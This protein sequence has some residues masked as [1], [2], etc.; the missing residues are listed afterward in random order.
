MANH[1]NFVHTR[2]SSITRISPTL[3]FRRFYVTRTAASNH[4]ILEKQA[5]NMFI[6]A[7]LWTVDFFQLLTFCDFK[8]MRIQK[9]LNR[10]VKYRWIFL[11]T[12]RHKGKWFF[13]NILSLNNVN[14]FPVCCFMECFVHHRNSSGVAVE[15]VGSRSF[16]CVKKDTKSKCRMVVFIIKIYK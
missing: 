11:W 9:L 5:V 14:F 4:I 16:S 13:F 10:V 15:E 7:F 2:I 1:S 12:T 8:K 6:L 3:V